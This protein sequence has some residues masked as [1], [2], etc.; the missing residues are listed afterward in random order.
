MSSRDFNP[1]DWYRNFFG[2]HANK[3]RG[4]FF[5]DYFAGF[6]EMQEEMERIFKV[7]NNIQSNAPKELVREY[8]GP[9]GTKVREVGPIV[10]GYSMTIEPSGKPHINQFGNVKNLAGGSN[11]QEINLTGMTSG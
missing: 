8:Q 7:F 2:R 6:E 5:D 1:F 9:D 4:G 10:Y 3:N 11:R